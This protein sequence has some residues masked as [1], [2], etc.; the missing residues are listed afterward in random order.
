MRIFFFRP[1]AYRPAVIAN[2][3]KSTLKYIENKRLGILYVC[4]FCARSTCFLIHVCVTNVSFSMKISQLYVIAW[5]RFCLNMK[6]MTYNYLYFIL[7]FIKQR[8][9]E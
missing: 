7:V 9:T 1:G 8:L 2:I 6:K 5:Y 4:L 3:A